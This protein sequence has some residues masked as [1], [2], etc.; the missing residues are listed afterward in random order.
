MLLQDLNASATPNSKHNVVSDWRLRKVICSHYTRAERKH[1][2][3]AIRRL[4]SVHESLIL[5][6]KIF[7]VKDGSARI[8]NDFGTLSN[9]RVLTTRVARYYFSNNSLVSIV[10]GIEVI[11]VVHYYSKRNIDLRIVFVSCLGEHFDAI[12]CFD[13]ASRDRWTDE[14]CIYCHDFPI[15]VVPCNVKLYFSL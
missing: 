1:T 6:R 7:L 5:I 11:N 10:S 13:Q 12:S 2:S 8:D 14:R 15:T 3:N 4:I 9:F